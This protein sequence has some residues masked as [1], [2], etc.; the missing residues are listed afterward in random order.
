MNDRVEEL[1]QLT[2]RKNAERA[3]L[4]AIQEQKVKDGDKANEPDTK[5]NNKSE[6]KADGTRAILLQKYAAKH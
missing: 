6:D 3:F 5:P 4:R 2:L 1:I